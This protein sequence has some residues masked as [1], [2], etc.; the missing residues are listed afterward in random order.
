MTNDK[1]DYWLFA[2]W[3]GLII[4]G[5][6]M[7]FSASAAKA[8][9]F[10]QAFWFKQLIYLVMGAVACVICALQTP[11]FYRAIAYPLYGVS[12]LLLIFVAFG[13][14]HDSHGAG[15]WISIGGFNFQPSELA[16][17][18]YMF[19]LGDLMQGRRLSLRHPEAFVK[20]FLFFVVPFVLILKQPNLSTALVFLVITL[21]NFYWAGMRLREIFLLL[22][23]LVSVITSTTDWLWYAFLL[24]CGLALWRSELK[25]WWIA[26]L[27]LVN[28]LAGF[29]AS[30]LWSHLHNHQRSRIMT[31][32]DPMRDPRGEG[33][34]VIQSK[35]AIGSG[36]ITGKGFGDGSQ[37]NLDFLPE[38]HT[39]FIFSVLGE[40]F[41]FVGCVFVLLLFWILIFRLIRNAVVRNNPYGSTLLISTAAIL[42][43]HSIVN[44]SMTMGMMP[45]TGLP[46]PFLSY[47]GTFL[48]T[49]MMLMGIVLSVRYRGQDA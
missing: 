40:Q 30:F 5:I 26:A 1:H 34:Q 3:F 13:G 12:V 42:G 32:L 28:L 9:H 38:D 7:V 19:V 18:A 24:A 6:T 22:S 2:A 47:G 14:G 45:V 10:W 20:P 49:C 35:V 23:P 11:N 27:G 33:Y 25:A 46:L 4:I 21:T 8:E 15:R 44:V 29:G 36:G 41:G 48:I 43:F 37:V 16:K 31:F 17:L 39:D